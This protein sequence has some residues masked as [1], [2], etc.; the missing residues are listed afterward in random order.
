MKMKWEMTHKASS[1]HSKLPMIEVAVLNKNPNGFISNLFAFPNHSSVSSKN[2]MLRFRNRCTQQTDQWIHFNQVEP[3]SFVRLLFFFIV[4]TTPKKKNTCN[5]RRNQ[6]AFSI[7][8]E[9]MWNLYFQLFFSAKAAFI[10]PTEQQKKRCF[11][12]SISHDSCLNL[13]TIQ[14]IDCSHCS[15]LPTQA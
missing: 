15:E 14:F 10:S 2:N 13:G 9:N 6:K 1:K 7:Y 8:I 11:T 4:L 3:R 12:F 5:T